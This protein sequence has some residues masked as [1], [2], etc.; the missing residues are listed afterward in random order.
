VKAGFGEIDVVLDVAEDFVAD[1]A[2][3][4]ETNDGF[5]FGFQS[6]TGEL[7]EIARI[8]TV[9]IGVGSL[10]AQL[11]DAVGVFGAETFD[12]IRPGAI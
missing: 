11:A 1:G 10:F 3:V 4:A 12:T 5:A 7:F 8:E 2:F 9:Q 6:F